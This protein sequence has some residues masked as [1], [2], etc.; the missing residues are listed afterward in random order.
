MRQLCTNLEALKQ[1]FD[2]FADVVEGVQIVKLGASGSALG[3]HKLLEQFDVAPTY[4]SK[5]ETKVLFSLI[6]HAQVS[7]ICCVLFQIMIF[8]FLLRGNL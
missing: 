1:A 3:V 5:V 2:L 6:L 8:I 4:V 7:L